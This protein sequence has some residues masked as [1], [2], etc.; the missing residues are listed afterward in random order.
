MFWWTQRPFLFLFTCLANFLVVFFCLYGLG[1]TQISFGIAVVLTIALW[2]TFFAYTKICSK[3]F[4]ISATVLAG[5]LAV[6]FP[7]MSAVDLRMAGYVLIFSG[8]FAAFL[9]KFIK[10][11]PKK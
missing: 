4:L 8:A 9:Y 11:Y 2:V 10:T 3:E 7:N 5:L 6:L 1:V